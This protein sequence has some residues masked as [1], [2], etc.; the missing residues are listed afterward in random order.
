MRKLIAALLVIAF[1]GGVASAANIGYIDVQKVFQEYKETAKAQEEISKKEEAFKKEFEESQKKLTQ[2]ESDG[3]SQEELTK[4]KTEL[5][6][7]LAPKKEELYRLNEQLTVKLQ[8]EILESV[9]KVSKK[10]G[11]DLV[12]D[13]IAV[14]TGGMD[15][16]EM[17]INDLNK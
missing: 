13:K 10:V 12:L 5:E 6:S 11:I 9:K 2:A 8:L 7:K 4:M 15:L 1:F 14:I 16:T 3:K 17:V